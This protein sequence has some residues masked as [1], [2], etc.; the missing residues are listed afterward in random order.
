M[1]K[2]QTKKPSS[3]KTNESQ[4]QM[5]RPES[6]VPTLAD[7]LQRLSITENSSEPQ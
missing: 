7:L 5:L 3:M 2:D 4:T 6:V 1:A